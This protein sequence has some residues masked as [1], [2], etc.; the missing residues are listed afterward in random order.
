MPAFNQSWIKTPL[1][2]IVSPASLRE[3][4]TFAQDTPDLIS[5][6]FSHMSSLFSAFDGPKNPFRTVTSTISSRSP[7]VYASIRSVSAASLAKSGA[8]T[9]PDAKKVQTEAFRQIRIKLHNQELQEKS[10]LDEVLLSLLLV[11]PTTSWHTPDDF[12]YPH[13]NMAVSLLNK[14]LNSKGGGGSSPNAFDYSNRFYAEALA[15]WWTLL[16]FVSPEELALPPIAPSLDFDINAGLQGLLRYPHP[17]TGISP[18]VRILF[19]RVGRLILSQRR[20]LRKIQF[21]S[22]MELDIAAGEIDAAAALEQELLVITL[23]DPADI[24]PCGD[25]DVTPNDFILTAE[26]FKCTGLLLLYRTFPDLLETRL[27]TI[28]SSKSTEMTKSTLAEGQGWLTSFAIHILELLEATSLRQ[29]IP[30]IQSLQPIILLA[31]SCE[32]RFPPRPA[33]VSKSTDPSKSGLSQYLDVLLELSPDFDVT[34]DYESQHKTISAARRRAQKRVEIITCCLPA[35]GAQRMVNII[36]E[37]QKR[38][39]TGDDGAFWIDV[40][41]D[42]EW[43]ALFG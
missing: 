16:C 23:P 10:T 37:M 25:T 19:G 35:V 40:M 6:Y 26:A 29:D 22:R 33:T 43:Y 11:G 3:A 13:Y 21:M 28:S 15:Y 34:A 1:I 42:R 7:V 39:D 12:G 8:I 5:H 18:E 14:K 41:I 17:M 31:I 27:H 38:M 2:P 32:M 9:P 36:Q 4:A 30:T 20:R 24:V